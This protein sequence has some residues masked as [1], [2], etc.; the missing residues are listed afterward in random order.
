M[1]E[2]II[3][4]SC[5]LKHS[6]RP[7]G[8]CPRCHQPVAGFQ[9]AAGSWTQSAALPGTAAGAPAAQ[10]A[11]ET[12]PLGVRLAGVGAMVLAVTNLIAFAAGEHQTMLLGSSVVDLLLGGA[13]ALGVRSRGLLGFMI[14]RVVAG[15]IGFGAYLWSTQGA[16]AGVVQVVLSTGF[17]LLLIGRAGAARLVLGGALSLLALGVQGVGV[18]VILGG[19]NPLTELLAGM[20]GYGAPVTSAEGQKIPWRIDL[21]GGHWRLRDAAATRRENPAIDTMLAWPAKDAAIVIIA[22]DVG[23]GRTIPID[24]LADAVG[25]NAKKALKNYHVLSQDPL[26]TALDEAM[27]VHATGEVNG[28]TV[29]G[30]YGVFVDGSVAIQVTTLVGARKFAELEPELRGIIASLRR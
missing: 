6:A 13:L 24:A 28:Q 15:G 16:A 30:L 27:M 8:S 19:D 14:F 17:L 22:E 2:W 25:Q 11:E 5:Q 10:D 23:A 3:C 20:Q 29:E 21:P 1:A 26:A 12:A 4:P 18:K 7:D 9:P